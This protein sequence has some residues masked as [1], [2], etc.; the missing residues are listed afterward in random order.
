QDIRDRHLVLQIGTLADMPGVF[1]G[2]DIEPGPSVKRSLAYAGHI[3]RHE[4]VATAV[5]LIGRAPWCPAAGLYR[6]P[7]AVANAAREGLTILV[8]ALQSKDRAS[9][10]LDAPRRAKRMVSDSG[11]AAARRPAQQCSDVGCRADRHQ[12]SLV[13]GREDDVALGV[14]VTAWKF[15]DD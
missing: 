9:I 10:L 2:A 12:H 6:Q 11:L 5:A 3:I 15:G 7:H 4:I 13:I 1:V 14:A 8:L